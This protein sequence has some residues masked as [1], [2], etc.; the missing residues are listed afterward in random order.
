MMFIGMCIAPIQR[1]RRLFINDRRHEN[2]KNAHFVAVKF[3][4]PA[5]DLR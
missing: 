2:G 4:A 1:F 5:F 3:T